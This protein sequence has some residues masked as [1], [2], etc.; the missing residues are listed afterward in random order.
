MSDL[1]K[2]GDCKLQEKKLTNV[3][4]MM[5][6][7]L[8][9]GDERVLEERKWISFYKHDD[10]VWYHSGIVEV[11]SSVIM[12]VHNNHKIE[13][14]VE[15]HQL[16]RVNGEDVN[17]IERNQVLDLSDE[18]ER[19]E[20]D[21]FHDEP[22]GWGVLYDKE[23]EKAYEGFRIGNVS[24]C[25]GIQYYVDIQ[26]VEY[27][28]E[29][30]EGKRWG[31]GIQYDR[32]SV[33]V[34]DGEWLN[35]G[36]LEK[37]MVMND[38]NQFLHNRI[39]ELIVSNESCNGEEWSVLD[40]SFMLHL[41]LLEVGD[42]CFKNVTEVKLIGL[43]NLERVLICAYSFTKHMNCHVQHPIGHFY[44]KDCE[45]LKELKMGHH[46]FSDFT[47]C[48]IENVPSLEVIEMGEL[49]EKSCT[50]FY[51]SLELKSDGDEMK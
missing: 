38:E 23:G 24:V 28:G 15:S 42:Y 36:Q 51:A 29:I 27:E 7:E 10:L 11:S 33:V 21:V 13:V 41:R 2:V 35:N 16:L 14:N 8:L 40:L 46:S 32:N 39:E 47:V 20:G 43:K 31:R 45:N 9:N 1:G 26:K 17:G 3:A 49:N 4:A 34:Y 48:E 18:G 25:Y 22:Y 50:F 6:R 30:C 5:R 19:W 44:L 37:R 12:E